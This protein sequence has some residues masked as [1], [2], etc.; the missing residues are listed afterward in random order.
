MMTPVVELAGSKAGCLAHALSVFLWK[1]IPCETMRT[2]VVFAEVSIYQ[3]SYVRNLCSFQI[4]WQPE[5]RSRSFL[6]TICNSSALD[7]AYATRKRQ[8]R[9]SA[10]FVADRRSILALLAD[11]RSILARLAARGSILALSANRSAGECLFLG[12][13]AGKSNRALSDIGFFP[14]PLK[15]PGGNS[16]TDKR[17]LQ[18]MQ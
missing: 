14:Q 17:P 18:Y 5:K 15:R 8:P 11:R 4:I 2:E 7:A 6:L 10:A 13:L 16:N 3:K 12:E 1:K 9:M